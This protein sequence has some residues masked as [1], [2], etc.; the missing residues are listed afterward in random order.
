METRRRTLAKA[1]VWQALGLV[2]MMLVGWV[3]TGSVG[4]AGGLAV[5][6]MALGF[7]CYVLH[8]RM[9]AKISWGKVAP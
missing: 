1:V 9:W 3:V 5:T 7:L 8:E 2:M 4:L 6:N